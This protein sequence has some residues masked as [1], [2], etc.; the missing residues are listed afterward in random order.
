[1]TGPLT[2]LNAELRTAAV[3]IKTLTVSGK[4]VTLAVF[5]QLVEEPA[6]TP[7]GYFAGVPWGTVNYCPG[8]QNCAGAGARFDKGYPHR[9]HLVWQKG[10]ELRRFAVPD[11][12]YCDKV[13]GHPPRKDDPQWTDEE[14]AEYPKRKSRYAERLVEIAALPQLFIAV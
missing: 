3:E 7:D 1:M 12:Y 13:I 6:I 4:Q 8:K 10:V 2:T 14:R 11:Y 5:R 9:Y